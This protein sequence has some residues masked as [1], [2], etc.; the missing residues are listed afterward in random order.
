MRT[1]MPFETRK[2]RSQPPDNATQEVHAISG[3]SQI[4]ATIDQTRKR[5]EI[6]GVESSVLITA[7]NIP[8]AFA[9]A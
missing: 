2:P 9:Y 1:K 7:R 8:F 5:I 6:I 3:I 4:R